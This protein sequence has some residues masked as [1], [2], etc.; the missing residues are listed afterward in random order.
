MKNKV[1]LT[2]FA[3]IIILFVLLIIVGTDE[4]YFSRTYN[5]V[6]CIDDAAGLVKGAPVLLGGVK[7]GSV[8][9]IEFLPDEKK[10]NI[11]VLLKILRSYQK[12][13]TTGSI[14]EIRSLGILG[15]KYIYIS[16][17]KPTE[18]VM[19]DE[20]TLPYKRG[21]ALDELTKDISPIASELRSVL[22]NLHRITDSVAV[23]N[24]TLSQLVNKPALASDL[25]RVTH[26]ADA[27]LTEIESKEG[28]TGR[29]IH[30][31]ELYTELTGTIKSVRNL[32]EGLE[33][34]KGSMGKLVTNDSLYN[35]INTAVTDLQ[36]TI[37]ANQSDTTLVGSLFTD[38]KLANNVR[39]LISEL[40]SLITDVKA[41]P[42]KYLKVSVF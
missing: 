39:S 3:G 30:D 13:I 14:A 35:N 31:K 6:V 32:A 40:D 42:K 23:G 2:V 36:K 5:L 22:V 9:K 12:K 18:T 1:G 15:D 16:V 33:Q 27:L 17:G 20:A 37:K 7:V 21:I 34:G 10:D 4:Y 29:L 41:N 38:R 24:G 8:E 28:T 26:H 19:P 11:H 25:N